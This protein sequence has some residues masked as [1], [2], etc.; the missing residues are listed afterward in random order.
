MIRIGSQ[1]LLAASVTGPTLI[2]RV[3]ATVEIEMAAR[4][5]GNAQMTSSVRDRI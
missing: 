5:T 1:R 3:S 2:P 4:N